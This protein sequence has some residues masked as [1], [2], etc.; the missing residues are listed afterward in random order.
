M[1]PYKSANQIIVILS[2][3]YNKT[4]FVMLNKA[5]TPVDLK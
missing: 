4:I 2:A 1:C 5:K 3:V